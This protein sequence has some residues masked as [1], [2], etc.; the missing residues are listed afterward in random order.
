VGLAEAKLRRVLDRDET[1]VVRNE[2]RED[3]EQGGLPAPRPAADDEI[4]P[5]KARS[6][7]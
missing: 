2:V 7:W 1:L 3:P 6:T 4:R 5:A